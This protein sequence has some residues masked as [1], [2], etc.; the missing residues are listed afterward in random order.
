MSGG[1][2]ESRT[3]EE[4]ELGRIIIGPIKMEEKCRHHTGHRAH[5]Q[6]PDR[7]GAAEDQPV[8]TQ[9]RDKRG[10]QV[11]TLSTQKKVEPRY[12]GVV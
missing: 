6:K 11:C 9:R 3:R 4:P 2:V 10:Q 8:A 12:K 7:F 5:L 1:G